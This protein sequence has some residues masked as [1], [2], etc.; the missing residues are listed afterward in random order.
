[1][2]HHANIVP[3][4]QLA[5][6]VGIE[7][8]WIP[9]TTDGQLDLTDLDQLLDG[10]AVVSFTA[11]SNVLG[12]VT[13]VADL[14]ARAHAAGALAVVDASQHVHIGRASCRERGVPYV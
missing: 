1:M 4:H 14:V 5:E 11:M 3:W 12:T 7:L 6:A 10:A 9:I 13:P 8:R 2:E